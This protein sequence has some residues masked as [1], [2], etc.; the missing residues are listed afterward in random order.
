MNTKY[1]SVIIA[2]LSAWIIAQDTSNLHKAFDRPIHR[3]MTS[4]QR[5][6]IISAIDTYE[7]CRL[8]V[9]GTGLDSGLWI[10]INRNG[11]THFLENEPFWID[12]CTEAFPGIEIYRAH[13]TTNQT[14]WNNLLTADHIAHLPETNLPYDALY[15]V[16]I[17][18]G[19]KSNPAMPNFLPP[20]GRMQSFFLAEQFFFN[21]SGT[22]HLFIHDADRT[23][24]RTYADT[25]FGSP[26][27]VAEEDNLLHYCIKR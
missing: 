6:M 27:L 9:I 7:K 25:L 17:I 10:N 22:V 11:T 21:T 26:Y 23:V 19:P 20:H 5:K 12:Y 14:E 24:E 3:H 13:Y 2:S 16:I 4:A 15:D 18:D 8:L 1:A